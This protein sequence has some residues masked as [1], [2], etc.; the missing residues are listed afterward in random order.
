MQVSILEQPSKNGAFSRLVTASHVNSVM[1]DVTEYKPD[2]LLL[3]CRSPSS[4]EF[5]T[6]QFSFTLQIID[7]L[8]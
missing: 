1:T 7:K 2:K 5:A 4:V 6:N 3:S 8:H